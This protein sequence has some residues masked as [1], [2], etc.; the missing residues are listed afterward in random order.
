M[1]VRFLLG[2]KYP[3]GP[4]RRQRHHW[5]FPSPSLELLSFIFLHLTQKTSSREFDCEVPVVGVCVPEMC[6]H[7]ARPH[8]L[9]TCT[10]PWVGIRGE[11][12]I[13]WETQV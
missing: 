11:M 8:A 9:G 5:T 13:V 7:T 2:Q 1:V 3:E 4:K 10:I 12:S 6:V